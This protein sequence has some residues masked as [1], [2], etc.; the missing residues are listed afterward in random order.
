MNMSQIVNQMIVLF[1]MMSV[2]YFCGK[3]NIIDTDFSKKLTN[4]ILSITT[5]AMIIASVTAN[6][7][8]IDKAVAVQVMVIAAGLFVVL[9]PLGF[10]IAKLLGAPADEAKLYTFMAIFSNTG[11]MGYPVVRTIFG[12]YAVFL[13]A[14]FNMVQG[15][16]LYSL[17]VWLMDS[18]GGKFN[19]KS[20]V[21]P[22]MVASVLA[23]LIFLLDINIPSVLS[24]TMDSIGSITSPAA[25]LLIGSSLSVMPVKE[26]FTEFRLY[27]FTAIK[28]IALPLAAYFV[29]GLFIKDPTLLGIVTV[30]V[31]MPVAN[32]SVMFANQ[33]GGNSKL[34]SKGVFITTMCSFATIP[35]L[36]MFLG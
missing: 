24:S 6:K 14:M 32:I 31:A 34:A 1:L 15:V 4:L 13:A 7:V 18:R 9:T 33:Y 11:F 36:C 26:I 17:G 35:L 19:P 8:E 30:I 2:G 5:P 12:D 28:Q 10:I 16:M 25:M 29:C 27:P 23:L 3:V 22:S 21:N 20:I